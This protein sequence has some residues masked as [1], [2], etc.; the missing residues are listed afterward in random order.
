[1]ASFNIKKYLITFVI[2]IISMLT[3]FVVSVN[4]DYNVTVNISGGNG[5]IR[6]Y[7]NNSDYYDFESIGGIVPVTEDTIK[8]EVTPD[9][10]YKIDS[11]EYKLSSDNSTRTMSPSPITGGMRYVLNNTNG[12]GEGTL[13]VK[14]LPVYTISVSDTIDTSMGTIS[15]SGADSDGKLVVKSGDA[16]NYTITPK[17]GYKIKSINQGSSTIYPINNGEV[18]S[19]LFTAT[20]NIELNALFEKKSYDIIFKYKSGQEGIGQTTLTDESGNPVV[21]NSTY[22]VKYGAKFNISTVIP[23]SESLFIF[24]RYNSNAGTFDNALNAVAEYT[25]GDTDSGNIIVETE[26]VKEYIKVSFDIGKNGS[27]TYAGSGGNV[28]VNSDNK[29]SYRSSKDFTFKAT[30]ASSLYIVGAVT[31]TPD[32][33]GTP[34]NITPSGGT[35][36]I[37]KTLDDGTLN[38]KFIDAAT[39]DI[40]VDAPK[41]SNC[42]LTVKA[43]GVKL[44]PGVNRVS[45]DSVITISAN[46]DEGS[47][48]IFDYITVD[49]A[50]KTSSNSYKISYLTDDISIGAVFEKVDTYKITINAKK[51]GE[52]TQSGGM[53]LNGGKDVQVNKGDY[54]EFTIT[55]DDDYKLENISYTGSDLSNIGFCRYRTGDVYSNAKLDVTFVST[56]DGV[57]SVDVDSSGV[58][59][60][61]VKSAEDIPDLVSKYKSCVFRAPM[62]A[63]GVVDTDALAAIKGRNFGIKLDGSDYYWTIYGKNISDATKNINLMVTTGDGI[64]ADR[65]LVPLSKFEDKKQFSIAH[66]GSFPFRADLNINVGKEHVGRYANLFILNENTYKLEHIGCATVNKLGYATY[67]MKHASDYVIVI[68]DKKL[69]ASDLSSSAGI[70]FVETQLVGFEDLGS[71]KSAA[72]LL[73]LVIIVGAVIAVVLLKSGKKSRE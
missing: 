59:I 17:T 37:P 65:L 47:G 45:A 21:F 34:V 41:E 33:S 32:N 13:Y 52:I 8:F 60:V 24:S 28:T 68:A 73:G 10:G 4:A 40:T 35:Y 57:V 15:I 26:F 46:T 44:S 27:I 1:M 23:D 43:D 14:F 48:Y 54:I 50:L 5:N 69:T 71:L 30:P 49:G 36:T 16:V 7:K 42:Y 62:S 11:V 3:V 56:M 2:S 72:L 58:T 9:S 6:V 66:D 12:D 55:P 70:E 51:G 38:V 31:Y 18:Y 29:T 19:G 67:G 63:S 39:Y 64:I 53:W 25:V 20:S 61:S 22:T